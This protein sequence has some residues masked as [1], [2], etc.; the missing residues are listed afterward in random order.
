[1][2]AEVVERLN[3]AIVGILKQPPVRER[4]ADA[5]V[6]TRST[7][8]EEFARLLLADLERWS[9]VVQRAGVRPE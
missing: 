8:S 1:M 4:L 7:T 2:P 5:G 3:A 6:D 9:R